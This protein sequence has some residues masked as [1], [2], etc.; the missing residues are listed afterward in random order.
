VRLVEG[1]KK[2]NRLLDQ[3]KKK[4]ASSSSSEGK[5]GNG[6]KH[7]EEEGKEEGGNGFSALHKTHRSV[8]KT[9]QQGADVSLDDPEFWSKIMPNHVSL[10]SLR[11]QLSEKDGWP[12]VNQKEEQ[13]EDKE[14]EEQDQV[15]EEP[16]PSQQSVAFM[17]DLAQFVSELMKEE[18]E[19][20]V[21]KA[22]LTNEHHEEKFALVNL[23]IQVELDERHFV[24]SQRQ[25]A[26][27]HQ[28]TLEG[29]SSGGASSSAVGRRRKSSTREAQ[30]NVSYRHVL[31]EYLENEDDEEAM[32]LAQEMRE[33]DQLE[34]DRELKKK[35]KKQDQKRRL[36]LRERTAEDDED[37]VEG[38]EDPSP[39]LK[40]VRKEEEEKEEE[41]QE[42]EEQQED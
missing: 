8:F 31:D 36:S 20:L 41:Q 17:K 12:M 5:G 37:Y 42:Q 14:E 24:E 9:Q 30:R 10:A 1:V 25:Q 15:E 27:F 26:L 3:E 29:N 38:G 13:E 7:M 18:E 28:H 34:K 16:E 39:P 4:N 33:L 35:K 19:S 11:S 21:T 32:L 23:C 40:K 22:R 2:S 6:T